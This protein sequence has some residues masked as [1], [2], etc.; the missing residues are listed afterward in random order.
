MHEVRA[1]ETHYAGCRFRSR[2]EARW[3]VF[4]DTLKIRWE[5]EPEGFVLPSG[6]KYLPDFWLPTFDGGC[7]VEVKPD[8]GHYE[9]ALELAESKKV[10]VWCCAGIPTTRE[11]HVIDGDNGSYT[12]IPNWDQA[13][14]ED[15][16]FVYSGFADPNN[17]D[18]LSDEDFD[19]GDMNGMVRK[20]IN[21][22]RSARFGD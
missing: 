17:L 3:A 9:K 6:K 21:A 20:A 12:G 15:R 7:Y 4:F 5:Y 16:M 1:I 11:Y 13:F 19:A 8:D 14:D 18:K 22:A 10:K 2:L